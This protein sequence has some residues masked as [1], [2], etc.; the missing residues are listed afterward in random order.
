M[1]EKSKELELLFTH[2]NLN[3]AAFITAYNPYSQALSLEE[4]TKRNQYLLNDIK[5]LKLDYIDGY[6]E[7]PSGKWSP[8]LSY[9]VI[10]LTL[11]VAKELAYKYEQNAFIWCC[12]DAM[13]Q[14]ILTHITVCHSKQLSL[15]PIDS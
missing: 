5:N 15:I 3:S 11:E 13:T 9:L 7:H 1:G 2:K 10:G 4:N 6:G 8:E 12:D 14:L